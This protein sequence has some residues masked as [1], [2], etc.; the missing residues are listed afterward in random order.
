MIK[1]GQLLNRKPDVKFVVP[2]AAQVVEMMLSSPLRIMRKEKKG[3]N[4]PDNN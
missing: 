1:E 4:D 3:V 2:L